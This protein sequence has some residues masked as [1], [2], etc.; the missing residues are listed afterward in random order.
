MNRILVLFFLLIPVITFCQEDQ[1]WTA[2]DQYAQ[3]A[4]KKLNQD[5]NALHD[6]LAS[7]Y[8]SPAQK[9]RSFYSWLIK[10][11]GYDH[12]A[13]KLKHSRINKNHLDVLN[14]K[15]AVCFGYS[16]L[17]KALCD[18][19]LIP[20]EIITG[21]VRIGSDS[22]QLEVPDH[23]WNAVLIADEWK[24]IDPTWAAA[25]FQSNNTIT[26]KNYFFISPPEFLNDHLPEVPMWQLLDCPISLDDFRQMALLDLPSTAPCYNFADSILAFRQMP[27]NDQLYYLAKSRYQFNPTTINGKHLGQA[28]MDIFISLSDKENQLQ[29]TTDVN[30]LLVLHQKMFELS[31][32]AQALMELFDWQKD[33]LARTHLNHAVALSK[34]LNQL[35]SASAQK[36]QL[37]NMQYH[38]QQCESLFATIKATMFT[39][40]ALEQCKEYLHFTKVTLEEMRGGD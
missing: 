22:L 29:S 23:T 6:Y 37:E 15:K 11:I 7:P 25:H 36:R 9:V 5:L 18:Q 32:K 40:Q 13:L 16:Q 12:K 21:Y 20:N 26:D 10:N 19:S 39:Q 3:K 2:I 33:Y 17:F 31:K 1:D 35:N 4:P 27:I 14:R 8:E 34:T 24:L 28:Y 38:L 30:K